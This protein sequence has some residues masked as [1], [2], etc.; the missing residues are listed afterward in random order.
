MLV[1]LSNLLVFSRQRPD[2]KT[3]VFGALSFVHATMV[4]SF[5]APPVR[6]RERQH[7][8]AFLKIILIAG[9]LG[10]VSSQG[11]RECFP[12][13]G[14]A[15]LKSAVND[16]IRNGGTRSAAG[17]RYGRKIGV[18]CVKRVASF[19]G[20]FL[21]QSTF[22]LPLDQWDTSNA[23]S[24][25]RMFEGASS[26]D[27]NLR[28][29]ATSRAT[30]FDRMFYKAQKFTGKGLERWRTNNVRNFYW[31]FKNSSMV[32]NISSWNVSSANDLRET[33]RFTPFKQNLCAWG[34]TLR[35]SS[36]RASRLSKMFDASGCPVTASIS[37]SG[38]PT[39]PL[40]H[41]CPAWRWGTSCF[42]NGDDLYDA[43]SVRVSQLREYGTLNFS[44]LV[45]WGSAHDLSPSPEL[46]RFL[47]P[48]SPCQ[49]YVD[50]IQNLPNNQ[51]KLAHPI[52]VKYGYPIAVW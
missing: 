43:V 40:C 2:H 14:N 10:S 21:G 25:A 52:S 8:H 35:R 4:N 45:T 49:E 23:T 11:Q 39:G 47:S 16:Y 27:Q 7:H 48:L 46:P 17:R 36:L 19:A 31:T 32:A 41:A 33:F 50:T 51:Q 15:I 20:V 38:S 30:S 29:F 42:A 28:N 22:N 5:A 3:Q 6:T 18:W 12:W 44:S 34:N 24:F 26:F 13:D 1:A 37:F 9:L